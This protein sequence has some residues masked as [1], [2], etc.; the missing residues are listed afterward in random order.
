[1]QYRYFQ[2]LLIFLIFFTTVFFRVRLEAQMTDPNPKRFSEEIETFVL[3]DAK[4]SFSENAVLFVGSSSIRLWSTAAYFPKFQVINRGFGGSHISDVNHYYEQIVKKYNPAR[5]VFYA[6]DNDM[7]AGKVKT[8]QEVLGAYQAFT[9]KVH[10]AL[11]ETPIYFVSI[12]P[13]GLRWEQWPEMQKANSLIEQ[14]TLT[15]ERLRYIDI[16]KAMLDKEGN[17]RK[18]I[19]KWDKLHLNSKGYQLWASVIK[20]IIVKD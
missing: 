15:D 2:S 19:F 12:K 3:W 13:S 5:I 11:P 9:Q 6:G 1:M 16:S 18:D 4:N 14:Y 10:Q 7:G 17:L 8:P 20:P